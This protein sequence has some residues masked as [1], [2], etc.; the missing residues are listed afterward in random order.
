MKDKREAQHGEDIG[1]SIGSQSS[2]LQNG[3]TQLGQK[4]LLK[5]NK[6]KRRSIDESKLPSALET[7]EEVE[8]LDGRIAKQGDDKT[9]RE[10]R[11]ELIG[12][13]LKSNYLNDIILPYRKKRE[14][15]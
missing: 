2:G 8:K 10:K 13:A 15:Q 12:Y 7:D 1:G 5:D 11:Q 6:R 14:F 9:L 3:A 4:D